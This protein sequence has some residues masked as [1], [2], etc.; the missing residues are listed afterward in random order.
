MRR[1]WIGFAAAL[2]VALSTATAHADVTALT[3][4]DLTLDGRNELVGV[5]V[6]ADGSRYVGDRG[7]G[8]VYRVSPAGTLSSVAT[9]LNRPAGLALD[10]NGR[11]LIAEEGA[12]RILRLEP[13]NSVTVL[14]TGLKTPRWIAINADASLYISAHRLTS[15]DGTD[16]SEGR[17]IVRLAPDGSMLEVATGI[18]QLQALVRVNGSLVATSKGLQSGGGSQGVLLR[19][20]VNPDGSLGTPTTWVGTGLKQPVG[21]VLDALGSVYVSSKELTVD[22]D[23]S[24]RAIGKVHPDAH[25]TDFAANLSDPQGMAVAPD[26]A[27]YLADGKSGRLYH[28]AAP[29]APNLDAFPTFT[30]Q[31]TLS[32]TGTTEAGAEVDVFVNDATSATSGVADSTGRFAIT[33]TLSANVLN[34]LEVFATTHGGDGLTS[35]P[36]T[37]QT[38]HDDVAPMVTF[39]EPPE[40]YVRGSVTVKVRATDAGSGVASLTLR[41]AGQVLSRTVAPPLP[42]VD[43]T[44]TATWDTT[45]V[46]DGTQTLSATATD[47]AG[48]VTAPVT[49]AV[50]VDNTPPDTAITDGPGDFVSAPSVTVTFTGT[51]NLTPM[52]Q[53]VF[54]WR[55][56]SGVWSAF[57]PATTAAL[58]QLADGSHTFEVKARDLAGNEDPTPAT[59]TFTVDAGAPIVTFQAPAADAYVRQA[60]SVQAQATDAG[61][62]V[63]TLTL[64]VDGQPFGG[65]TLSPAPPAAAVTATATWITTTVADGPHTLGATATDRAGN[66]ASTTRSVT[67]DN[68]APDAQISAGPGA[69]V[70]TPSVTVTFTGTDN[71]TPVAQLVFA[72]R[73]DGGTWSAFLPAT[74]ATLT[75]LADGAHTFE[76][77]ARDLAGN[78]DATPATRAFTVDTVPPTVAFQAPAANGYVR[79]AVG[80]QAQAT[81]SGSGVA[82]LT[83]TVDGQALGGITL[84]PAPPAAAVTATATWTTTT[85]ADGPHTLGAA[86]T[87]RAN[88]AASATRA[89]VVDNTAPDT[90]ITSGP[91]GEIGVTNATFTFTGSDNLTPVAQLVFAWR[92]DGGAWSAFASATTVNLTGLSEATHTFEV[93]AR[94]L[95]GNEDP[96][97]AAQTFTVRLGPSVSD[98]TPASGTI[99]TFVTITGAGFEPGTTSVAFNGLAATV[100]AVTTTQITTTVPIGASTGLLVVTTSR[101]SAS[102]AFTVTPT[103]DFTLTASPASV[104]AIA[105]DQSAVSIAAGGSGAFANL[106]SL[107]VSLAPSGITPAFAS[108]FLA[109]GGATA[110]TFTVAGTVAPGSYQFTVSGDATVDGRTVTRTAP[111]TLEVLAPDTV[112]LTGRILTAETLPQPIPGVTVTLGTALSVTDAA[113]NFVVLAPPTG[114]NML[115]VDGRTA[116]T[117]SAQFPIVEVQTN[118]GTTGP[119]R[120][121]FTIYLPILDTANAVTLPLDG[122]GFTTQEVKATT[123]AMPGL[124][125]T[126]PAGT[127][128]IGPDGNPVSQLVI[129]PVPVDRSPMPFPAGITPPLL[130]AINPGGS[131]PSQPLPIT[132]PNAAQAA[133]GTKADLYYFDLTVGTWSIWGT[134]TVTADGSQIAS[135]PGF[136]LPRL[137]WHY[138]YTSTSEQV[139][140]R[141]P[142]GGDPVDLVTG[143]FTVKKTDL[144]LPARIPV[145]IQRSYHNE[146]GTAGLFGPGWNLAPYDTVLS[147]AGAGPSLTLILPDQSAYLFQQ[148][149]VGSNEWRNFGEPFLAGAV[150]TPLAGNFNFQLR[151]KDGT[152][153]RFQKITGFTA[154]ALVAIQD[155]NGNVLTIERSTALFDRRILSITEPAGR[156]LFFLYDAGGR[157]TQITDPIGRTVRYTYDAQNRLETVTDPG[158]GVTRYTYEGG[159]YRIQTITDARGITYLTNEYNSDARVSRQTLADGGVWQ[160]NYFLP[161]PPPPPGGGGCST[162]PCAAG[163]TEPPPSRTTVVDPRTNATTY[164]FTSPFLGPFA[165]FTSAITD[166]LQQTT[167]FDTLGTTVRDALDRDTK[168]EYDAN[169]NLTKLTDASG[170]VRTYTYEPIFNR[171]TSVAD[172]LGH[173]TTFEYDGQGNLTGV[174]DPLGKRT[175]IAYDGVGQPTSTTDPLNN[176]TAFG[177][178][179]FGNLTSI[180]DPLGNTTTR[181]YDTVGRLVRQIDPRGKSTGFTYDPLNRVTLIVDPLGGQTRF[182]YDP[183]GNLLTVTDA[184]GNTT[185]YTYD[186]MDRVSS[187]TDPV[188]ATET[189]EYDARGNLTRHVDRKGQ[190]ATFTYDALNRRVTREDG[191]GTVTFEYDAVG[192]MTMAADTTS[193]TFR[194]ACDAVDR[195]TGEIGPLGSM[196]Y[197]YDPAGRRTT[198]L[199]PGVASVTYGYDAASRL[200]SITQ[201]P[202][203]PVTIQYDDAGRRTRL[204]LP[205][206]VSTEYQYDPASRL[207]ALIYRNAAGTLGDLAYRYDS[208]GNRV[209]VGGAFARTLLPDA[210][211]GATYDAVNRQLAF[212]DATMTYDSNGSPTTLND[213]NGLS[214]FG[215][216]ARGRLVSLTTPATT[217]AFTYDAL[218]RRAD[219][220]LGA[221]HTSYLYDGL[222]IVQDFSA[223]SGQVYLRTL[224]VDEPLSRGGADFYLADA[225]GSAVALTDAD[226]GV[227]TRYTYA[228]FGTTA[229]DGGSTNPFQFTA[230]EEDG[231]TGLY[232]YRARYYHPG[233]S[234]FISEDPIYVR[235]NGNQ[236]YGYAL[237]N[238]TKLR[239]P[240]GAISAPVAGLIIGAVAGAVATVV[241]TPNASLQEVAIGAAV[242][243]AVGLVGGALITVTGPVIPSAIAGAALGVTADL[244][245][246]AL[247]NYYIRGIGPFDQIDHDTLAIAAIQG[248]VG[249]GIAALALEGG[250]E[251]VVAL[252]A[253]A[254]VAIGV[255]YGLKYVLRTSRAEGAVLPPGTTVSLGRRK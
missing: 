101:G 46:T 246:Q 76:V 204:T 84:S 41:A 42:D 8:I 193:G 70:N 121:P 30:N 243:G 150:V 44:A 189:F 170:A 85:V 192:R 10:A 115:F 82:T 250:A 217:A 213:P 65:V 48:N 152:I 191:A 159:N 80:V 132:F 100:R 131:V 14:A 86:A 231:L 111:V 227:A 138:A 25:V 232:Y 215:W 53:L 43:V 88:N 210:I 228:P 203:A 226:G 4:F 224:A 16:T 253:G 202:L 188:G 236:E 176:T 113:G 234:R 15:P 106:V 57:A 142:K 225:L 71:L 168:P 155:R 181:Q 144:V 247:T 13:D 66:S 163:P 47:G 19:Y 235:P 34:T 75:A 122:G 251:P 114:P 154:A 127:R 73:L 141:H 23:T 81:D 201:A 156:Q 117:P 119:T 74:T 90:V 112:A 190:A 50:T 99:G 211:L 79:Q 37:A 27:L 178:D 49:H 169:L 110:L 197:I 161:A 35:A 244:T 18:S 51:D 196:G 20:P 59:R 198:M 158:G 104:R 108:T 55:V 134:G 175:A 245:A 148:T 240:S 116:S 206:Q 171:L 162:P 118:V 102:R 77:K 229:V 172:P 218:G 60:V 36:A 126:V 91:T 208:A 54:A 78:E 130:F 207:T 230:R 69:F 67:V 11:L 3:P 199:A 151:F 194:Y 157:I 136:G 52:A 177:Y 7:A 214:Q 125:V 2:I 93:K 31:A 97:P 140:D 83:L 133:P 255:D 165:G 24:K 128:I 209:A 87:D 45:A 149:A 145:T 147:L 153:H 61:S 98:I 63:A 17:T 223:A 137:A 184:R 174:V 33:V 129:T 249:G 105:G 135:D 62:G 6:S 12:G 179:A 32:V 9:N 146:D 183:N 5:A 143:R 72:W 239:D 107:S 195:L 219:R 182:T 186:S 95:A 38:T 21:L 166:A 40:G 94:D 212:G 237:N 187:R 222:D 26:G 241:V 92:L 254:A 56:D 22:T 64:A 164:T 242:G 68:T 120:V 103:G 1:L 96:T 185:T 28:F 173:V 180:T 221:D 200:T 220:R 109:P 252:A 248:A 139:R 238:P 39:Q 123:P 167:F 216:D 29:V 233:L 89:V 205:N 124:V 160:F 58:S